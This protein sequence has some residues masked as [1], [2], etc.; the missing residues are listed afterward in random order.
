MLLAK[1]PRKSLL[2]A[3]VKTEATTSYVIIAG[4]IYFIEHLPKHFFKE[5]V[6][7]KK[8]KEVAPTEAFKG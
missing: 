4:V 1:S 7:G 3:E 2:F 6:I 8:A 5:L